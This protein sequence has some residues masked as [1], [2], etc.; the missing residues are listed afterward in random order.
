M[1]KIFIL[2]TLYILLFP[3]LGCKKNEDNILDLKG[4]WQQI[5]GTDDSYQYAIINFDTIEIYWV[6]ESGDSKA[7]YWYGSFAQPTSSELTYVYISTNDHSKTSNALL[8]SNDDSKEFTYNNGELSYLASMLGITKIIRLKKVKDLNTSSNNIFEN[9]STNNSNDNTTNSNTNTTVDE[10]FNLITNIDCDISQYSISIKVSNTT[11]SYSLINA[12]LIPSNF[13]WELYDNIECKDGK[14]SSKNV[15]L[16]TGDNVFYALFKNKNDSDDI[17]LYKITINRI[18]VI[19]LNVVYAF[20]PGEIHSIDKIKIEYGTKIEDISINNIPTF[21]GWHFIGYSYN[22][23]GNILSNEEV[24]KQNYLYARY[25]KDTFEINFYNYENEIIFSTTAKYGESVIYDGPIPSDY[26]IGNTYYKFDSWDKEFNIIF[27]NLNIYPKYEKIELLSEF[28]FAGLGEIY[29]MGNARIVSIPYVINGYTVTAI[30]ASYSSV[31]ILGSYFGIS[32]LAE[33]VEVPNTVTTLWAYCF[34]GS[35]E[36]GRVNDIQNIY[37]N[38]KEITLPKNISYISTM[39]FYHCSSLE[40]INFQG[41][42]KEWQEI[43]HSDC[44]F[45]DGMKLEIVCIDGTISINS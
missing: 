33:S 22:Y 31:R 24:V 14:I 26:Y 3:L 9:N 25:E 40:K 32:Y 10:E 18:I 28:G 27:T 30:G 44:L 1:K 38:L 43:L 35:S 20:A 45:E 19:D 11:T 41:T 2:I 8:A 7:L 12:F 13:E 23:N 34:L 17:Y 16:E 29:S 6:T 21:E 37:S 15:N 4:E 39:A 42:M 5:N 36:G